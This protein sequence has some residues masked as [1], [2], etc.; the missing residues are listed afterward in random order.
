MRIGNDGDPVTCSNTID[1]AVLADYWLGG[2]PNPKKKPS[3][4]IYWVATFAGSDCAK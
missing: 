4:S 2:W 3:R 1:A